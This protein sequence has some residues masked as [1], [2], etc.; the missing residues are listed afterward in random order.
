MVTQQV[1]IPGQML[2]STS[3]YIAGKG[4]HVH[5]GQIWASIVGMI[6]EGSLPSHPYRGSNQ[7]SASTSQAYTQPLQ[8]RKDIRRTRTR[9]SLSV[10]RH[11]PHPPNHGHQGDSRATAAAADA[12][13]RRRNEDQKHDEDGG[14]R[15]EEGED[16]ARVM[17]V[18]PAVDA[19]VL[20]R[21]TR[22]NPRQANVAI[23]VI[24]QT[25]CADEF[26][27]IIR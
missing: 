23:L 15:R 10:V 1:A 19:I 14:R 16:D 24:G 12:D 6:V 20:A 13:G 4:T 25:V 8:T 27:G 2:G 21:V 18:L 5:N 7:S 22:I 17:N 9:P 3:Q 26:P 11:I